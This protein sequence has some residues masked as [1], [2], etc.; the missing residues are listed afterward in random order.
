MAAGLS[1]SMN[2]SKR[3]VLQ[4]GVSVDG[5]KITDEKSSIDISFERTLKVGKRRFARVIK[6][7]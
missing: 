2:E 5:Q 6:E 3:L 7:K 4:G 1:P